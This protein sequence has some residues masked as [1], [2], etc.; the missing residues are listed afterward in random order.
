MKKYEWLVKRYLRS[1]DSLKLWAENP[2][3]NPDG[4]YL[5]LLDY[6][7]ELLSDNSEKESFVKLLTSISEKGFIPS[8]PIV[9]WRNEDDTHCYVAEGNRRVLALKILRNPK[10]APKSIRPL[11][12]Q[13]SSNTNLDDIQKIFVCIAP[14]FDDTIWYINERH[15][16]S[17]LQ[18]PWS[19]IQHQR[20][21][22]E[23]YQKYNGD[24]DSILAETSAERATV[25]ADIRILKLI[26]LI[27]QPQ[28][29]NI[30]S[31]EEYEKAVS[32]RF[33]ITIL[34][35]F[36]NYSDVKKAWFITFDGTNVIIKAEKN[37]FLKLML[38]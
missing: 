18:K 21:I 37:S 17:A 4:K 12:K 7:E 31:E 36:F 16:P 10:K 29:K 3:L 38:S 27:K 8:D 14:S 28:I 11:V 20:W 1:V 2:R 15:N 33:P 6:V 32:H 13:L 9:V 26:D 22:F 23:L 35:R 25:E 30:L 5:N 19:R 34:E 24:I